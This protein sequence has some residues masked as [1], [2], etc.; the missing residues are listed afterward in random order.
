MVS[1]AR[2]LA[3]SAAADA[4]LAGTCCRLSGGLGLFLFRL[5]WPNVCDCGVLGAIGLA[6]ERVGAAE[7]EICVVRMAVRPQAARTLELEEV[8]LRLSNRHAAARRQR[9]AVQLADDG[10]LGKT[11]PAA[12]FG[13]R[14]P[15]LKQL[16][17]PVDALR[18][19]GDD[20]HNFPRILWTPRSTSTTSGITLVAGCQPISIC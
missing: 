14:Q 17:Q 3:S 4:A 16:R 9:D 20:I 12:D 11:Q 19:P 5:L 7:M 8:A 6:G 2:W 10:V 18:R 15:L 13:G 1:T